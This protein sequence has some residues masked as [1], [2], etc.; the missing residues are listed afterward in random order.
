MPYNHSV[1]GVPC[2]TYSEFWAAEA[3]REGADVADVMEDYYS[4]IAQEEQ[5]SA[6]RLIQNPKEILEMLVQYYQLDPDIIEF[7]PV[8][9]LEVRDAV[10]RISIRSNSTTFTCKVNC[11]DNKVRWL[12]Y[13]ETH[14][15]GSYMD[16]PDF[17]CNCEEVNSPE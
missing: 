11:N 17:D 13:S 8:E 4:S 12:K 1:L 10:V 3:E 6:N 14:Y 16:P 2:M 15:S 7:L 9:V 5:D